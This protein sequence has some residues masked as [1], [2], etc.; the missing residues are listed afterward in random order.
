VEQRELLAAM[1]RV[2]GVVDVEHDAPGDIGE[3]IAEQ[4]DHGGHH[5]LERGRAWQ[6]LEPAHGR[7][8]A[9]V[10]PALGQAPDGHLERR[11]GAQRIAVVGVRAAGRD[12]Q[13]PEADHLRCAVAHPLRCPRVGEAAREPLGDPEPALDLRQ[14]Q[15]AGIRGQAAAVEGGVHA[16]AGDGGRAG[17]NHG[18]LHHGGRRPVDRVD[19]AVV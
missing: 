16:L 8:R 4:L 1:H 6:V 12:Q 5:P 2:A 17:S 18:T 11:V 7:L 3:A 9:Q 19:A 15:H 14:R 13:H 10:R